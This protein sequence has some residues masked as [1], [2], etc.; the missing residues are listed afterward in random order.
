MISLHYY[1]ETP[2]FTNPIGTDVT[3]VSFVCDKLKQITSTIFRIKK[4]RVIKNGLYHIKE[5][6]NY[7]NFYFDKMHN[8]KNYKRDDANLKLSQ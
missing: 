5:Y 6:L 2:N 3:T 4:K 7:M 1:A 8:F